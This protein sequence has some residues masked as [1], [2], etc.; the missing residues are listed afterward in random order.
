MFNVEK[1]EK[2]TKNF[3]F[4]LELIKIME[5]YANSKN[6]S[7]NEL[8]VKCCQYAMDNLDKEQ[9]KEI[10]D[11]YGPINMGENSS[12]NTIIHNKKEK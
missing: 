2:I 4:P 12:G 6:I 5:L 1:N 11:N 3:R 8:V 9:V 7:L 10:R